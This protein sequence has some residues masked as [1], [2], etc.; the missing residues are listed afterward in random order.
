MSDHLA[1][2]RSLKD[3]RV[4]DPDELQRSLAPA[5][6]AATT[7]TSSNPTN[8]EDD[9]ADVPEEPGWRLLDDLAEYLNRYVVFPND[10]SADAVA[11]WAVHTHAIDCFD[12]T[13]RLALLSP[14]KGSGKTRVLEVLGPVVRKALHAVNTTPAFMFRAV[15]AWSP[16]LLFDEADTYFGKHAEKA[17]EELRGLVNAGHRKGAQAHRIVGEG[18]NMQPRSFSAFAAVAIA[19][20]GDLPETI[21]HRSV[22]VRMRRRAPNEHV[23]PYRLR[24]G[25]GAG[26][27]LGRR[28]AAWA[29]RNTDALTGFYPEMPPGVVDRPADV[30]EALLAIA[31]VAGAE[32][33]ERARTACIAFTSTAV[34]EEPSWGVRLLEDCRLA[35]TAPGRTF[36]H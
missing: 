34:D 25:E 28:A 11:L 30:W 7:K 20:L 1:A 2:G 33:R 36:D 6:A 31:E 8:E 35:L 9:Y 16:T 4:Y 18:S 17:H 3:M 23:E 26:I 15:D 29:K 21:L 32:W 13:P 24:T 5:P 19:G 22:L 12:S 27:A 10:E 14:E